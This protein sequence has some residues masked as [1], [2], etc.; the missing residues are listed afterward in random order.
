MTHAAESLKGLSGRSRCGYGK[1]HAV[2]M[3][4]LFGSAHNWDPIFVGRFHADIATVL[5][6]KPSR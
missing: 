5:C 2:L 6:E 3:A 4:V 1:W